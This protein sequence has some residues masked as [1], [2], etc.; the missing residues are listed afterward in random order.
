MVRTGNVD[1]SCKRLTSIEIR[2]SKYHIIRRVRFRWDPPLRKISG[3]ALDT[4]LFIDDMTY[5]W[6]FS[7]GP[8]QKIHRF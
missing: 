7:V 4:C 6:H 5:L 8:F 3:S 1:F 2:K